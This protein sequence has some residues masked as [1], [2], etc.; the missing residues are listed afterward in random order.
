MITVYNR[1]ANWIQLDLRP[2]R[3]FTRLGGRNEL[4]CTGCRLWMHDAAGS[5]HMSPDDRTLVM[6]GM[7]H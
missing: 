6:S 4:A 2:L 3:E 7:C 1:K 5:I